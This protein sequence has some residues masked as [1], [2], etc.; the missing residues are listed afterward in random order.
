MNK[1]FEETMRKLQKDM[2]AAM[3][4]MMQDFQKKY[5]SIIPDSPFG[6]IPQQ[7][8]P[9]QV[10]GLTKSATNKEIK[11]RYQKMM[12]RIHPD[13]AGKEFTTLSQFVNIAY[14]VIC[15][16]RGI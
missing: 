4:K 5:G 1:P 11:D 16:E 14:M 6:D 9:Y 7:F 2:S 12:Q 3:L 8:D 10:I 13:V 15:Q